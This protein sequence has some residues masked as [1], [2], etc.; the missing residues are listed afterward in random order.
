MLYLDENEVLQPNLDDC[1]YAYEILK[2]HHVDC[3][4]INTI[5]LYLDWEISLWVNSISLSGK[6]VS[7]KASLHNWSPGAKKREW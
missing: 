5:S 6:R 1:I 7:G 2:V 4:D 3:V